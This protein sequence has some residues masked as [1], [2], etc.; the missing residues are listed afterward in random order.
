MVST[1]RAHKVF[2]IG[3]EHDTLAAVEYRVLQENEQPPDA[4]IFPQRVPA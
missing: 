2:V 3:L 4:D 1:T